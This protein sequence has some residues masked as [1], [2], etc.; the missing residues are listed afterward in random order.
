MVASLRCD[1]EEEPALFAPFDQNRV[2][3]E[4]DWGDRRSASEEDC[5][6]LA[7]IVLYLGYSMYDVPT[8]LRPP[9]EV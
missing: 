5:R 1:G 2:A 4:T 8:V 9:F 7:P 3:T 6:D